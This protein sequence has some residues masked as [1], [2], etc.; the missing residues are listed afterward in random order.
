L[1]R[2]DRRHA[3][4]ATA[5]GAWHLIGVCHDADNELLKFYVDGAMAT[6]A[7]ATGVAQL[8]TNSFQWGGYNGSGSYVGLMQLGGIWDKV[9]ADDEFAELLA[10]G[11]AADDPFG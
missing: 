10:G 7:H 4:A 3:P 9:I 6:E 11:A 8:S 5:P 1:A 2:P